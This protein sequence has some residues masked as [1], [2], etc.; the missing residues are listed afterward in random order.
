MCTHTA[1]SITLG[2]DLVLGLSLGL[3]PGFMHGKTVLVYGILP[4]PMVAFGAPWLYTDVTGTLK[5][6]SEPW[7]DTNLGFPGASLYLEK[8][9]IEE[10]LRKQRSR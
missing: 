2:F 3:G 7:V 5:V 10:G 9:L 8:D 1:G 4:M 6:G